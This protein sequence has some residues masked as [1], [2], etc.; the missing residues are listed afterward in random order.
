M[1]DLQNVR[2]GQD[3]EN[4]GATAL[5]RKVSFLSR[6]ESY[7]GAPE[8]VVAR[9]THMSWV[10]MAGERVYKLKKSV[11]FPYLDFS[12]LE[13]RAAACRAEDCLNRR[14]APDVYLGVEPLVATPTGYAI[15][16][17]GCVVDWLVVMR[18]LDEGETLEAAPRGRHV[19][20]AQVSRLATILN[21]FYSRAS[22]IMITPES[23]LLSLQKAVLADRRI[24]RCAQRN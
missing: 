21:Q 22:R 10:F 15:G 11:R 6:P 2:S 1:L 19:S 4:G 20:A 14:L 24:R 5:A 13:R 12:T 17:S 23:Y 8:T 16:G 7:V 18:R 3:T 9:E